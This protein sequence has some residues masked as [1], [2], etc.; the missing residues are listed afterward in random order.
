METTKTLTALLAAH[1]SHRES[2]RL[3]P[4]LLRTARYQVQN[5]LD[6]LELAHQVCTADRLQSEQLEHWQKHLSSHRTSRGLPL[7]PRSINK[8]VESVRTFLK[9]LAGHGLIPAGLVDKLQYVKE[10]KLLPTSVLAHAQV[11]AVLR[12]MDTSH[13]EGYRDRVILELL[14]TSGVRA[15]EL[16]GLNVADVDLDNATAIVLGKGQKQRVV[17]VG[18]TALRMLESY[19]KAVRPFLQRNVQETAL[20]LNHRG[21]RMAYHTLWRLVHRHADRQVVD[22]NV[23]PHTFRR[24]CT[25][26]LIRGGANLYHVKELLGHATLETLQHYTR[27]TIEDLKKTHEKCHPRERGEGI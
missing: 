23:T 20:F 15:R 18:R 2:L 6:W 1:Q 8:Q 3:S 16:L 21:E 13:S 7:K 14:Y 25:T 19:I 11:K 17:P 27:L 5:F 26:E 9:Y 4:F 24:S 22:V 10:P 12:A